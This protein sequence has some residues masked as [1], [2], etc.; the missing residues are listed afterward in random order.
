[1][2][3]P[4]NQTRTKPN[5]G[6]AEFIIEANS[7]WKRALPGLEK[8]A[9]SVAKAIYGAGTSQKK[10]L[11]CCIK[12]AEDKEVKELNHDFRGKPKP[13]NVLS[14]PALEWREG[15]LLSK[16]AS[17]AWLGDIILARGVVLK[18]AKAQG[19]T[20]A[21]HVSHLVAHGVLHL[22]GYDHMSDKEAS[23]MEALEIK[24]LK[25]LKIANPYE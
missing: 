12:F 1:M 2:K 13:T 20:V 7:Q 19:K 6:S 10:K 14:F 25:T 15:K 9:V 11:G 8:L 3:R 21:A 22:I 5:P 24:L 16:D 18:E 23:K 4:T 17:D